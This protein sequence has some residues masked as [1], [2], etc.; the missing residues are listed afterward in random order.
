MDIKDIDFSKLDPKL[1]AKAEKCKN[2]D[3]TYGAGKEKWIRA[4]R[5]TDGSY[6][7]WRLL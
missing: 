6:K 2:M 7:R 4:Y 3:G 1:R 5:F